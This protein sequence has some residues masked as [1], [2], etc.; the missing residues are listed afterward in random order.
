[1]KNIDEKINELK[2]KQEQ[3]KAQ[4]KKL[5]AQKRDAERKARTHRLIQIGAEIESI[6]GRPISQKEL[7][8]FSEFL[9]VYNFSN[10]FN[11]YFKSR[12]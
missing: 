1:M 7:S 6:L 9:L 8:I 12:F 11:Q 5:M 4:E 10:E 3:L 2:Q